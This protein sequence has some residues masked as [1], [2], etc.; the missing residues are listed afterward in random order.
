MIV[1]RAKVDLNHS[2][3]VKEFRKQ[4]GVTVFSIASLGDGVPDIVVGYRGVTTLV[5][6]KSPKGKLNALQEKWHQAWTG[7][8]VAIVRNVKDTRKVQDALH[9]VGKF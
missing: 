7:R 6:I 1:F 5:E 4:E 2:D 8:P 9:E 3:I